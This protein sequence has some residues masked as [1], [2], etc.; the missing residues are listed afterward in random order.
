MAMT[1][2]P[3]NMNVSNIK[4]AEQKPRLTLKK[5]FDEA[6]RDSE[7]LKKIPEKYRKDILAAAQYIVLTKL[8][9]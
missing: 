7:I 2:D 9:S 4:P 1:I 6:S 5:A 3:S 8:D